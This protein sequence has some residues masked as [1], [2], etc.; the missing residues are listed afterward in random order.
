MC[1]YRVIDNVLPQFTIGRMKKKA[2]SL[3]CTVEAD[4]KE[5]KK[6]FQAKQ[7]S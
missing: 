5:M 4:L 1:K 2:P 6:L 3:L 7:E